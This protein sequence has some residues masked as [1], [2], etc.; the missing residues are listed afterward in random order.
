M[1]LAI[2]LLTIT[3]LSLFWMMIGAGVE[4]IS[5][6][7]ITHKM[8][9]GFFVYF[10]FFGLVATPLS[11]IH[12]SWTIFF[13]ILTIMNVVLVGLS[14]YLARKNK[15]VLNF[16]KE[17]VIQYI[18]NYW[19]VIL[20]IAVYFIL[21]LMS[22]FSLHWQVNRGAIWDHS[23]YAS[24]ALK[25]IGAENIGSINPKFG[26]TESGLSAVMT[27]A[28][29]WEMFWSYLSKVSTLSINQV[30]KIVL[31]LYIYISVFISFDIC[32][33]Y[34]MKKFNLF[35]RAYLL[36][37][38]L[39]IIYTTRYDGFQDEVSKF[40]YV[41]WFGNVIVTMLFFTSTFYFFMRALENK[42][43]VY[44]LAAQLIFYNVFSA[45]G[46]VYAGI[47]YP[48]LIG[49]WIF[50]KQYEFKFA[51]LL[52]V[53][54]VLGFIAFDYI[55][56]RSQQNVQWIELDRWLNFYT[57]I[58]PITVLA[59]V[60]IGLIILNNKL[61]KLEY[62]IY[63][64]L[65]TILVLLILEPFATMLFVRYKFLLHRFALSNLMLVLIFGFAGILQI[66][67]KYNK[68]LV[69]VAIIP[70]LI[71]FQKS[72]D[73]FVLANS[74]NIRLENLT[75]MKRE[76]SEVLQVSQFLNNKSSELN[77]DVYYCS[78]GSDYFQYHDKRFKTIHGEEYI[79]IG[80]MILTESSNIFEA[81]YDVEGE[82]REYKLSEFTTSN[83]D[84]VLTDSDAVVTYFENNGGTVEY[85][86]QSEIL[87]HN[88]RIINI[89]KIG[90]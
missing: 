75:N 20:I 42:T 27:G 90:A 45:G 7:P 25:T 87:V 89:S 74:E 4:A 88:V 76:S 84:F 22:D 2:I 68:K 34:I 73:I 40:L 53:I 17:G 11:L 16:T 86:V 61:L 65:I 83:C 41:P 58:L 30:S 57:T 24:K 60:G 55:Y 38:W 14:G 31:P 32:W 56:I 1:D 79:D 13:S 80:S 9:V 8:V 78:Y 47:L 66:I 51:K 23:F 43:F 5:K 18:K 85:T 69:I 46:F 19:P 37:F 52:S 71:V 70:F 62:F 21:Y 72:Y 59:F 39:M 48:F 44:V 63:G 12:V 6:Q 26:F 49:Y 81:H 33:K 64:L 50:H 29:T 15:V 35:P 77:R 82:S 28:V 54:A 36:F 10:T 3:A 67:K